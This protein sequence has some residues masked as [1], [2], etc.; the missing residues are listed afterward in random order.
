MSNDPGEAMPADAPLRADL[1]DA[2]A[3]NLQDSVQNILTPEGA[4]G[5]GDIMAGNASPA[6]PASGPPIGR[7]VVMRVPVTVQVVLGKSRLP[8]AEL[9]QLKRGSVIEL[10]RAIGEPVDL[11]VNGH[12]VARGEIV[13][14]DEATKRFGISLTGVVNEQLQN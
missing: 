4:A 3:A 1:D 6:D 11:L 14:V 7:D 9:A 13:V 12:L 5:A 2:S 10:D 8:V